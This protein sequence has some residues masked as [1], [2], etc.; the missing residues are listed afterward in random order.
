M[1]P[2]RTLPLVCF[3][4]LAFTKNKANGRFTMNSYILR[5]QLAAA[6]PILEMKTLIQLLLANSVIHT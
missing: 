5:M 3:L 2:Q 4:T 6:T 1:N